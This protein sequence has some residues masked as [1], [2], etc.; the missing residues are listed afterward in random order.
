VQTSESPVEDKTIETSVPSV[1]PVSI[2][3]LAP[4]EVSESPVETVETTIPTVVPSLVPPSSSP[5]CAPTQQQTTTS[6]TTFPTSSPTEYTPEEFSEPVP[7]TPLPTEKVISSDPP[8]LAPF[9]TTDAPVY[10]S[11]KK[12]HKSKKTPP[13]VDSSPTEE[14]NNNS[15]NNKDDSKSGSES[16]PAPV[17]TTEVPSDQPITTPSPTTEIPTITPTVPSGDKDGGK[18]TSGDG[19]VDDLT[20]NGNNSSLSSYGVGGMIILGVVCGFYLAQ[21]YCGNSLLGVSNSGSGG[22]GGSSSG[23]TSASYSKLP[24]NEIDFPSSSLNED[25]QIG[26]IEMANRDNEEDE[27]TGGDWDEWDTKPRKTQKS[28]VQNSSTNDTHHP[29]YAEVAKASSSVAISSTIPSGLSLPKKMRD[30]NDS[31]DKKRSKADNQPKIAVNLPSSSPSKSSPSKGWGND[32]FSASDE[33]EKDELPTLHLKEE[34]Q[35]R[36]SND[37][38]S[39]SFNSGNSKTSISNLTTTRPKPIAPPASKSDDLFAVS[40]I[41]ILNFPFTSILLLFSQLV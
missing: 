22:G 13:P 31:Y 30:S 17:V 7:P 37:I 27:D 24:Q 35:S 36:T 8:T 15:G 4:F 11:T 41:L 29:S 14:N 28:K 26:D 12:P 1:T 3:S 19:T 34:K 20:G 38:S 32:S 5:S 2:P 21:R 18:D 40:F 39:M 16:T 25:N 23:S 6:S 33:Q 9:D 10:A